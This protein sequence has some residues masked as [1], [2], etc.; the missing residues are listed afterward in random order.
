MWYI[1]STII[2]SEKPGG[3][4][5]ISCLPKGIALGKEKKNILRGALGRRN[6][7]HLL[8]AKDGAITDLM[9]LHV[10]SIKILIHGGR[11]K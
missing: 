1:C 10:C 6:K 3:E 8:I 4:L 5:L 7:R 11:A 2:N 9:F